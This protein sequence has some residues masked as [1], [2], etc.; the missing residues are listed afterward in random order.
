MQSCHIGFRNRTFAVVGPNVAV[1][2]EEPEHLSTL[3]NA[4]PGDLPAELVTV[5]QKSETRKFAAKRLYFG[6]AIQTDNAAQFPRGILFESLGPPDSQK[7]Q[8]NIINQSCSQSIEGRAKTALN[9]LG[10][11]EPATSNKCRHGR[12]NA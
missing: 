8:Q 1:N 6:H 2:I 12:P 7:R 10:R 11:R 9:F 5:L 3:G 4:L